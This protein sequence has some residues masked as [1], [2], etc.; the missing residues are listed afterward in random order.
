MALELEIQ[1]SCWI[2]LFIY[3]IYQ[4]IYCFDLNIFVSIFIVQKNE[5][6]YLQSGK[7]LKLKNQKEKKISHSH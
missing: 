4:F 1:I 7:I 2:N 6:I 5:N 3:Y